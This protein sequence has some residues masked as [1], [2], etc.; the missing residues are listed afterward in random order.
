MTV[1]FR[2]YRFFSAWGESNQAKKEASVPRAQDSLSFFE[3]GY[4]DPSAQNET[5]KVE[6]KD[7][8]VGAPKTTSLSLVKPVFNPEAKGNAEAVPFPGQTETPREEVSSDSLDKYSANP[9]MLSFTKE[10]QQALGPNA[11][12]KDVL[13]PDFDKKNANNP[14]VQKILLKYTKDPAFIGLMQQMMK[15]KDF[16]SAF[17]EQVRAGR[18]QI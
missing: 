10:L 14:Q 2:A 11:G 5:M 12:F 18:G 7:P 8:A 9:V 13:K 17:E 4:I 3:S 1:S 6:L 16:M 15:D